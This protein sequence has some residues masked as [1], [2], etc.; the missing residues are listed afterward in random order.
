[1]KKQWLL[2]MIV[3]LLFGCS[4][5]KNEDTSNSVTD[6]NEDVLYNRPQH[7]YSQIY[8]SYETENGIISYLTTKDSNYQDYY[9]PFYIMDKKVV[10]MMED[11]R[12][13]CSYYYPDGC[14]ALLKAS[15]YTVDPQYY[16]GK[17]YAIYHVPNEVGDTYDLI[18][19]SSDLDGSNQ[20][21]I[22]TL[23]ENEVMD[24]DEDYGSTYMQI[25]RDKVYVN[26]FDK[27][28][29]GDLNTGETY[30]VDIPGLN[31]FWK[32]FYL[33]DTLYITAKEYD[34]GK[35]LHFD[36]VLEC[37]LDGNFKNLLYEDVMVVFMDEKYAFY[38]ELIDEE[39]QLYNWCVLDR[40][41]DKVK[42]LTDTQYYFILKYEDKYLLDTSLFGNGE[43]KIMILNE[44]L[45]VLHEKDYTNNEYYNHGPLFMGDKYYVY[46]EYYDYG[47]Q[48]NFGYY[49]ISEDGISDLIL[50][51]MEE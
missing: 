32:T 12:S 1:M 22:L 47:K 24:V 7:D 27:L 44:D 14:N 37:D 36:V 49:E 43:S 5:S 34:D 9:Y 51:E 15:S 20:K 33:E 28:Y 30:R 16:K 18:V 26:F 6:W 13:T 35:E 4:S 41:T 21:T 31:R 3:F 11:V 25:H 46:T 19:V 39:K 45:E 48:G 17:L 10:P 2:L 42:L 23:F 29:I 40:K 38:R 50:L 8:L